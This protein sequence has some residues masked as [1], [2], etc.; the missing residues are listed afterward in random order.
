MEKDKRK[1]RRCVHQNGSVNTTT[2]IEKG[3]HEDRQQLRF[4]DGC[5]TRKEDGAAAPG[6]V[7]TQR[8][9]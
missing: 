4:D 8:K 7:L 5:G 9:V 3:V 1:Q 6:M 2:G